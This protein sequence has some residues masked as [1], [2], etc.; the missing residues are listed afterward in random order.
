MSNSHSF[1]EIYLLHLLKAQDPQK[2][3]TFKCPLEMAFPVGMSSRSSLTVRAE[4][5][6]VDSELGAQNRIQTCLQSS[7]T[8][9]FSRA[10]SFALKADF[11]GQF[12]T[13]FSFSFNEWPG[14]WASN[15]G[16]PHSKAYTLPALFH[17]VVLP[18]VFLQGSSWDI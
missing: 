12:E 9:N 4:C 11:R 15:P 7:K 3:F 1:N 10:N 2:R 6:V 8:T 13:T 17:S 14:S 5:V 16:C 18:H